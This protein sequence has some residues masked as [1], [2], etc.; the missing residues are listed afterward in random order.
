LRMIKTLSENEI[1]EY[2]WTIRKKLKSVMVSIGLPVLD[3]DNFL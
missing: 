3:V 1:K 2:S